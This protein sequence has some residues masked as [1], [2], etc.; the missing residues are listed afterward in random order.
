MVQLPPKKGPRV[1]RLPSHAGMSQEEIEKN[2]L[3]AKLNAHADEDF[4]ALEKA[5]AKLSPAEQEEL[6]RDVEAILKKAL[7]STEPLKRRA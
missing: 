5:R 2:E 6:D 4:R 7:E 3:E 1:T